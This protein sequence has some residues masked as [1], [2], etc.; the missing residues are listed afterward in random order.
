MSLVVTGATGQLGRLVIAS[1]LR[2]TPAADIVALVR[3]RAKAADLEALGVTLRE[4][5]YGRPETLAQAFRAGD[6]VLLISSSELG[7]RDAQHR[8]VIKAASAAGV[9]Q[10]IYTSV[11]HADT[12]KLGLAADHRDTEAALAA[13]GL[14]WVVLRNGWYTEN[15]AASIPPALAHNAFI[16]GAGN[17]K[18]S[19]AARADYADA[20]AI[21]LTR[22]IPS[23]TIYELA[24][25]EAYTLTEFAAAIEK[26]AGKPVPYVDMS[27][28]E[29]KKAL[30][31]A[32]LPEPVA[33]LLSDSDA[34][35]AKGALF[36]DSRTLSKLIGRPTTPYVD[37]V[38][39]AVKA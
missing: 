22:D 13:S 15:Y 31:G 6:K 25:D 23:G 4:A 17:G 19:S 26:A 37:T 36:D 20:A 33:A 21:V 38:K 9:A 34:A 5:D 27:E 39:A 10:V 18:I 7:K 32:G 29:F 12:S 2:T 28:A 8:A 3:S 16:G 14:S 1:L 30:E 11:L 24:G 35:A